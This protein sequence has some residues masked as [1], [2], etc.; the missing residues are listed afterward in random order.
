MSA[1]VIWRPE[2][3]TARLI[4]AARPAA[5]EVAKAAQLKAATASKRVAAS[6]HVSGTAEN[7]VI[8][9]N[10]PLGILFEKGVRSHEI[11]PK[12]NVLKLADGGFVTGPVKH[13]GMASKPFLRP[14]LPLWAPLYR[15]AAMAAFRGF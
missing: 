15:R 9:A 12:K 3:L 4:A 2:P 8:G 10:D 1:V 6:I 7:F 11:N 5:Y 14:S 13:P